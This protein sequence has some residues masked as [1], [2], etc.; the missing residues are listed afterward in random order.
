MLG[1]LGS[2]ALA[3]EAKPTP[4]AQATKSDEAS[5]PTRLALTVTLEDGAKK[6]LSLRLIDSEAHVIKDWKDVQP[7]ELSLDAPKLDPERYRLMAAVKGYVVQVVV[8][9]VSNDGSLKYTPEKLEL[10]RLRYAILRYDVNIKGK[11]ALT[12]GDVLP[13]RVAVTHFGMIPELRGD[14]NIRQDGDD[15]KKV[16][17]RFQRFGSHRGF[18]AIPAGKTFDEI[19]TAPPADE[20]KVEELACEKGMLLF[21][22]VKG[23]RANEE[24]YAKILI[25]DV[26]ETPPEDAKLIQSGD[27]W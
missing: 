25:E 10:T 18:V 12:G 3:D 22:H 7:G 11:R 14:Y 23:H 6:P 17:F 21:T 1:L 9:E 5:L 20:Y 27:H 4:D 2:R 13:F 8:I 16:H 19:D 26:T 15:G 24:R